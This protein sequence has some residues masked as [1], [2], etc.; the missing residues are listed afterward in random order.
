MLGNAQ[1]KLIIISPPFSTSQADLLLL[2]HFFCPDKNLLESTGEPH[3]PTSV[4]SHEVSMH[5]YFISPL[6]TLLTGQSEQMLLP[7][8]PPACPYC[9]SLL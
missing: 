8:L 4:P 7:V 6:L 1:I 2:L 5:I 9:L 3:I